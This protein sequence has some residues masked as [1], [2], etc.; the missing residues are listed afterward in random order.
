M[1]NLRPLLAAALVL[2]LVGAPAVADRPNI[3]VVIGD[4]IGWKDYGCY[5]HPSIRTPNIDAL[6]PPA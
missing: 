3:L 6:G 4:D 2:T 5:G 1:C